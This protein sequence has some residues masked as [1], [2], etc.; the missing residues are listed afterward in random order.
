MEL[1]KGCCDVHIG[2]RQYVRLCLGIPTV[3]SSEEEGPSV[4][5]HIWVFTCSHVRT[6]ISSVCVHLIC[7][8]TFFVEYIPRV[9]T[10]LCV[11]TY[12]ICIHELVWRW[13]RRRTEI[14]GRVHILRCRDLGSKGCLESLP[15]SL[16]GA[17]GAGTLRDPSGVLVR[18]VPRPYVSAVRGHRGKNN[19]K[20]GIYSFLIV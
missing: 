4:C 5:V 3:S 8:R 9:Y 13:G 2:L 18:S 15:Q 12:P 1:G 20:G 17:V 11:Y 14:K 19:V 16:Q 6:S 7:T 10:Y